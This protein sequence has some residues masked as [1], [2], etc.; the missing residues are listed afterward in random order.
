MGIIC[1]NRGTGEMRQRLGWGGAGRHERTQRALANEERA[2]QP[3]R[4]A[5][6]AVE[7][8][9][10]AAAARRP[11]LRRLKRATPGDLVGRGLLLAGRVMA[12][13]CRPG[14]ELGAGGSG[15][16]RVRACTD[17]VATRR[18]PRRLAS[19]PG[20]ARDGGGGYH[21]VDGG[22][23]GVNRGGAP[24]R[25]RRRRH[26]APPWRAAAVS[27]VGGSLRGGRARAEAGRGRA[28]A[29]AA[30]RARRG[31]R[32]GAGPLRRRRRA[33]RVRAPGPGPPRARLTGGVGLEPIDERGE[34]R[35]AG[36]T[37]SSARWP[38]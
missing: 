4:P 6:D 21:V 14:R 9:R 29:C 28:G 30:R 31:V 2:G 5:A 11:A 10:S 26:E 37:P 19:R 34:D 15:L 23:V 18:S 3:P 12:A 8:R 27:N 16:G 24:R 33:V 38:R 32:C 36:S 1:L 25:G 7:E 22:A 17:A 13:S 20:T 35:E